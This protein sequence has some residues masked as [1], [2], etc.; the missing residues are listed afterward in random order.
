MLPAFQN[1][2]D[3]YLYE[4]PVKGGFFCICVSGFSPLMAEV[5]APTV[6]H[7]IFG[8]RFVNKPPQS[9]PVARSCAA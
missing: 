9:P 3:M 8:K 2:S 1:F 7:Q 4:I 6:I 5:P